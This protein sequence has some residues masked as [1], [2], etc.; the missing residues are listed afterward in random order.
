M[1]KK[2]KKELNLK[3]HFNISDSIPVL[4][5]S[6]TDSIF[7]VRKGLYSKTYALQDVNFQTAKLV[8]KGQMA[9]AY[10]G[11]LDALDV[12]QR[13]QITIINRRLSGE[14]AAED[15]F[16]PEVGDK[17]DYL[18]VCYNQII[19]KNLEAG[20]NNVRKEKYIT[21]S[22]ECTDMTSA[23]KR[24]SMAEADLLTHI[25]DVPGADLKELSLL[26]RVNL[27]HGLYNPGS[28]KAYQ[29]YAYVNGK[30]VKAFSLD[31]M[32]KRGISIR[33]LMQPASMEY[34]LNSF[35]LGPNLYG[36]ALDL[37][38]MPRTLR[39]SF[40]T[41]MT[42]VD[43]DI[44]LSVNIQKVEKGEAFRIVDRK[45]TNIEG[46]CELAISQSG[47]V[48]HRLRKNEQE[49]DQLLDDISV[50]DQN[51]FD[52]KIHIVVF[53]NTRE[54]L[55]DHISKIR[56]DGRS[57]GVYFSLA[58]GLQEQSFISTMPFG[59]DCTGITRT[60][61]T[62]SIAGLT[63][64]S[65]QELQIKRDRSTLPISYGIN[66]ISKS[67]INFDRFLGDSYGSF[68]LGFTGSGKSMTAKW[69]ILANHLSD[70]DCDT[71]II[72]PQ[73]EYTPLVQALGGQDITIIGSGTQR[74]NPLDIDE[75]YGA[76]DEKSLVLDPVAAKISFLISMAQIM[77]G[78]ER[79]L[80][81]TQ[82]AA[83]TKAGKQIYE[84]WVRNGQKPEFIPT[85]DDLYDAINRREDRNLADIY[86][87]LQNIGLFTRKEGVNVIFSD[88]TNVD[89]NNRLVSFDIQNMKDDLKALAM[90]IILDAI[91]I[92]LCRNK[93]LKRRTY[94]Y[95]DEIHLLFRNP[96]VAASLSKIWK[97][98]RKFMGA[99]TG[100]TQDIND[101]L[102]SEYGRDT[103]N[104]SSFIIML[105]QSDINQRYLSD[106]FNFSNSQLSYITNA[107]AG[108]GLIRIDSSA[109]LDT[110]TVLTIPFQNQIPEDSEI[111]K[112]IT[113]KVVRDEE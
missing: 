19:S 36:A 66:K 12:S 37:H 40:L 7:E 101:L 94:I 112:L 35:C 4:N 47:I 58:T 75:M 78:S 9:Q 86:E 10:G 68:I 51:L 49:V 13:L 102:K 107:K 32:Y 96:E 113:T 67:I 83:I 104:G 39:D 57:K 77:I 62:A 18:R 92:R 59:F 108:E 33:E 27:I 21:L 50:R 46:D 70:P 97:T 44:I 74:I 2:L 84:P 103:L 52:V 43:F 64:F 80:T 23:E 31:S 22:Q 11:F 65:V 48:P 30:K 24:F 16:I 54:E 34:R 95:I 61:T 14:L 76:E 88:Q 5:V 109:K 17:Q 41:D 63:P 87:L 53:G 99:P 89:I 3:N 55:N 85:M 29:E 8:E 105:K 93:K 81:G 69:N 111:Y 25:Q 15:A 60:M 6:D 72:D 98:V 45:L 1:N 79:P 71:F 91:W 90:F 56:T 110:K 100:I 42:N 28:E 20:R 106:L 82:K 38:G 73:S 26:K